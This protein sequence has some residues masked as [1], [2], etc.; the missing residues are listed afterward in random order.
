[1][2]ED[3]ETNNVNYRYIGDKYKDLI[4]NIF[5]YLLKEKNLLF[6]GIDNRIMGLKNIVN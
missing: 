2:A 6:T 5:N 4:N 1:M 3:G